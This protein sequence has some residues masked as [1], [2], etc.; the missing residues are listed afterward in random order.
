MFPV[1]EYN[2]FSKK[3]TVVL[4][5]SGHKTAAAFDKYEESDYGVFLLF[6]LY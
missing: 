5:N 2:V 3:N 6:L 4:I 1:S